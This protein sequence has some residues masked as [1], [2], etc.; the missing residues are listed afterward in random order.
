MSLYQARIDEILEEITRWALIEGR[1]PTSIETIRYMR[2]ALKVSD[3]ATPRM[4]LR[5]Q[6]YRSKFNRTAFNS[7]VEEAVDDLNLLYQEGVDTMTR[8][9]NGL[10]ADDINHRALSYQLSIVD[11]LLESLL[12]AEPAAASYF[13]NAYDSFNDLSKVDVDNTTA[14]VD[15]NTGSARLP[16]V[17]GTKKLHLGFLQDRMRANTQHITDGRVTVSRLLPGTKFG[18]LFNDIIG[19]AWAEEVQAN[20]PN[21]TI[22]FTIPIAVNRVDGVTQEAKQLV[23]IES[24]AQTI[25]R[26]ELDPLATAPMMAD[27]FYSIDGQ[28]FMRLP[29]YN[30]SAQ[31]EDKKHSFN[32]PSTLVKYLRVRLSKSAD[33][34]AQDASGNKTYAFVFGLKS[35]ALYNSGFAESAVLTSQLLVPNGP[36]DLNISKVALDVDERVPADTDIEYAIALAGGSW[37]PIT[38]GSR[39]TTDNRVVEFGKSRLVSRLQNRLKVTATPSV[40]STRN[41]LTF[42]DLYQTGASIIAGTSKLFRGINSWRRKVNQRETI[43]SVKNNYV[44]FTLS[45]NEQKLYFEIEDEKITNPPAWDGGTTQTRIPLDND[46]FRDESVPVTIISGTPK[47]NPSYSVRSLIRLYNSPIGGADANITAVPA[48]KRAQVTIASLTVGQVKVGQYIY[49]EPS[50]GA[51]G[52]YKILTVSESGTISLTVSDPDNLLRTE[53][54]RNWSVGFE[55]ITSQIAD[56]EANELIISSSQEILA[57]DELLVTYRRPLGPEHR[58]ISSSVVVRQASGDGEVYQAGRDYVVKPDTKSVARLAEGRIQPQGDETVVRVDF[59]YAV[60]EPDLDTYTAFFM[61]DADVPKVVELASVLG[62][63][64]DNGEALFIEDGS[65]SHEV[66]DKLIWPGMP[67]G[68]RQITVKSLPVIT[69]AGAVNTS[70]GMYKILSLTDSQGRRVFAPN[71]VYFTRQTAYPESLKE[72]NLFK[73]QTGVRAEDRGW[74]ALDSGNIVINWDPTTLPDTIYPVISGA[75]LSLLS[76]EEFELEYRVVT[77]ESEAQ[78]VKLRA[79]F[80]RGPNSDPSITPELMSYNLKFSY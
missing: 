71:T 20:V 4:Q 76:I 27:V 56:V 26:V 77:D 17:G 80:T 33:D 24:I 75:T 15:L 48:L 29:G 14:E 7:T 35:I 41:G 1:V 31:L 47:E 61:V 67:R 37:F 21:M 23:A 68:W 6:P 64:A 73:L 30:Q 60:L 12:L 39:D 62:L 45:D 36:D 74:Y 54:G 11:D 70:S 13:F 72:T 78:Q 55:D 22:E 44:V 50:T 58:L 79:T 32:F 16:I 51:N 69:A 8:I 18:H 25:S 5:F 2:E 65:Q 38:P 53:N 57:T 52:Y 49:L 10:N 59:E 40:D 66:S 9:L 19:D 63:D 28:N 3:P 46:I 42:Y 34:V 43:K